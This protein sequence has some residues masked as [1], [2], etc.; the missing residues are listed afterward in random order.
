MRV[1]KKYDTK[2]WNNAKGTGELF[3]IDMMDIDG[4][5]IQGTFYN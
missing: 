3:N 4:T 5:Q 2:T 1:V